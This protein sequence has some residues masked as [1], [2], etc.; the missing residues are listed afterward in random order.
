MVNL[1]AKDCFKDQC[2]SFKQ[3]NTTIKF[4]LINRSRFGYTLV[5]ISK[6]ENFNTSYSSIVYAGGMSI[7]HYSFKDQ[8]ES[9][10]TNPILT[11]DTL[12]TR[13]E[14]VFQMPVSNYLSF[15]GY[16]IFLNTTEFLS[17]YGTKFWVK[18]RMN[19]HLAPVSPTNFPLIFD[20]TFTFNVTLTN[21]TDEII[22]PP[23]TVAKLTPIHPTWFT[24]NLFL[25]VFFTFLCAIF[26]N[27]QPLKSRGSIPYLASICQFSME[28]ANLV[29]FLPLDFLQKKEVQE[30]SV[31]FMIALYFAGLSTVT[32][33]EVVL[34]FRYL[35]LM[36]LNKRKLLYNAKGKAVTMKWY[37]RYLKLSGHIGFTIFYALLYYIVFAG[38]ISLANF[39]GDNQYFIFYNLTI[40]ACATITFILFIVEFI[41]NYK[42]GVSIKTLI[43]SIYKEDVLYFKYE[44]Y[45]IGLVVLFPI[46]VTKF[47]CLVLNLQFYHLLVNTLMIY[48]IWILQV[49]FPLIITI[50]DLIRSQLMDFTDK[51]NEFQTILSDPEGLTLIKKFSEFEFS[52]ENIQCFEMIQNYKLLKT[53]EE[54][55]SFLNNFYLVFLSGSQSELEINIKGE[56]IDNVRVKIS[57]KDVNE[58]T[59]DGV[60]KAIKT[61]IS[62][63]FQRFRHTGEYYKYINERNITKEI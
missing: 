45:V 26:G 8:G 55:L 58:K 10:F 57:Q 5:Q 28:C 22:W 43:V 51:K 19:T 4:Q 12:R 1:Q 63:T 21:Q 35:I 44:V 34:F 30:I 23:N 24:V 46:F 3:E 62:D 13:I 39:I 33:L 38:L 36:F 27:K 7:Y 41:A 31:Y 52:S 37:W 29:I 53:Q 32:F 40:V 60:E 54:Q 15:Q 18:L 14:S 59:L 47:I 42:R 11:Q 16:D 25:Y 20:E 9:T 48:G 2:A 6:N 17:L 49:V 56:E 50:V 61:N